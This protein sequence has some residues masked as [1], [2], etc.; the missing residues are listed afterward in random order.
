[1]AREPLVVADGWLPK[2]LK[3]GDQ[4][5]D[6][7]YGEWLMEQGKRKDAV[8]ELAR[9]AKRTKGFRR[10][11]RGNFYYFL[12]DHK[13]SEAMMD[14]YRK[15]REEYWEYVYAEERERKG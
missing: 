5:K 1:V 6:I 9:Y 14:A 7:P 15:S 4:M 10:D 3:K 2:N 11:M 12:R 13:A 8:G